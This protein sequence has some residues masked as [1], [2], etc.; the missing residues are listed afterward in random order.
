M[1]SLVFHE[2]ER[3]GQEDAIALL[4]TS[5][6]DEAMLAVLGIRHAGELTTDLLLV[7]AQAHDVRRGQDGH[8]D[9][10]EVLS[11]RIVADVILGWW[12]HSGDDVDFQRGNLEP[13]G[14][15]LEHERTLFFVVLAT[16]HVGT[17]VVEE[18]ESHAVG[19][20]DMVSVRGP[21]NQAFDQVWNPVVEPPGF[22]VPV[23]KGAENR[24]TQVRI[25]VV[26]LGSDRAFPRA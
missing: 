26:A 21:E 5:Q 20:R 19:S 13:D 10:D 7:L 22:V 25:A 8:V 12:N 2:R 4:Q 3:V 17:V 6:E 18:G 16:R 14:V 15:S 1:L 24:L 11:G 23:E 9:V